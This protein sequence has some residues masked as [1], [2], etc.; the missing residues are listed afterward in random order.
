MDD[1]LTEAASY[2]RCLMY[3]MAAEAVRE[4]KIRE[5]WRQS[6]QRIV[7]EHVHVI[8][9]GPGATRLESF[10]DRYP[11]GDHRPNVF[12]KKR[13]VDLEIIA[14]V[15][16]IGRRRHATQK[17]STLRSDVNTSWVDQ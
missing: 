8:M 2:G 11:S 6:D 4:V 14:V 15:V 3:A 1:Q 12:A 9:P 5:A 7:V 13:I 10:K 17:S 16:G